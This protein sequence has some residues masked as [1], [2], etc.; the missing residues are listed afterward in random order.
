VR[1]VDNYL[2]KS[3]PLSESAGFFLLSSYLSVVS[4]YSFG[5]NIDGGLDLA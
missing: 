4:V 2:G 5:Y 3:W 1:G